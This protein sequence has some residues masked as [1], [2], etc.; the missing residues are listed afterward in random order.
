MKKLRLYTEYKHVTSLIF[1]AMVFKYFNI[2]VK[3][4]PQFKFPMN[5]QSITHLDLWLLLLVFFRVPHSQSHHWAVIISRF[6][7]RIKFQPH[8]HARR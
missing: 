3:V 7:Y 5:L 8:S 1:L 2:L 6:K 4:S